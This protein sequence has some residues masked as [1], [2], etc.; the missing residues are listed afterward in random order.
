MVARSN[1][2]HY[3]GESFLKTAIEKIG[4][5]IKTVNVSEVDHLV[6]DF[7]VVG[8]PRTRVSRRVACGRQA[9]SGP[10]LQRV[11]PLHRRDCQ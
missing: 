3:Y 4:G 5:G 11:Q 8:A 9:R 2:L 10:G 7:Q 6:T 1:V